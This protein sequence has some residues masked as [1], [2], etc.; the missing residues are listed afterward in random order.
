M[1]KNDNFSFLLQLRRKIIIG[2]VAIDSIKP[3]ILSEL[4]NLEID[5]LAIDYTLGDMDL[6]KS[7]CIYLEAHQAP[8]FITDEEFIAIIKKTQEKYITIIPS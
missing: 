4:L 3:S 8:S 5:L 7:L 2:I 1:N 6:I